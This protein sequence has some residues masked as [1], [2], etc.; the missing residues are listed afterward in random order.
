MPQ[1]SKKHLNNWIP[2]QYIKGAYYYVM[3]DLTRSDLR[4]YWKIAMCNVLY[5]SEGAGKWLPH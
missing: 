5:L 1:Q 3:S 4:I 2:M